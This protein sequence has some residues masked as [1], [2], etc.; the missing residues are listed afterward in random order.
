MP[1]A[2]PP[3]APRPPAAPTSPPGYAPPVQR[4]L[5]PQYPPGYAPQPQQ[6]QPPPRQP[7]PYPP[8]YAPQ[9]PQQPP[10]QPSPYPPG[11][12]PPAYPPGYAP[13]AYPPRAAP[14][15]PPGYV[16]PAYP[17]GPQYGAQ[18]PSAAPQGSAPAPPPLVPQAPPPPLPPPNP[19][20]DEQMRYRQV[21][22]AYQR[23]APQAAA[24][25]PPAARGTYVRI[26]DRSRRRH[27]GFY[28]RFALGLGSGHDHVTTDQP[29]PSTSTFSFLPLRLDAS[30]GSLAASTEVAIGFTPFPGVVLGVGSFTTTIPSLNA[31]SKDE[32]TGNYRFRV[33][34]LAILGPLVDW[35]FFPK[36]G[37]HAEGSPGVATYV[38]G[39]GE[40]DT[41][42]PLAQAHTAIGF[43]FMLGVGYDWW[44]GDQWSLGLLGRISYG[45]TSGSDGTG[46]NFS[47]TTYAPSFLI[48]MTYH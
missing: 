19:L 46:A 24:V 36:Y 43:G 30:G 8:G 13:P 22:G 38:A 35:Y 40:P 5:A 42:G 39:A 41:E 9:Q 2:S 1:S 32:F 17:Y 48:T 6:P 4:P 31:K 14:Q 16:P 12:A 34:Q 3:A 45:S 44:I 25:K 29:L 37:F 33:S 27:D 7:S 23:T 47:H 15:Y 26:A 21:L 11:Y 18:Q 28:F 10:R 20:V